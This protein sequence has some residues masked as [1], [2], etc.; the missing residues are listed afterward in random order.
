MDVIEKN[1]LRMSEL[2]AG[3]PQ[4]A[5]QVDA[6]DWNE[7]KAAVD[8]CIFNKEETGLPETYGPAS[9][10]RNIKTNWTR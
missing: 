2:A 5:E 6:L 10:S 7:L 8:E 3:N 9:S 1:K 4:L